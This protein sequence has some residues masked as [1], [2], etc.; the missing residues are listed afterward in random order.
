MIG[1]LALAATL[2]LA[3]E[4]RVAELRAGAT[5]LDERVLAI[6]GNRAIVYRLSD[7]SLRAVPLDDPEKAATIVAGLSTNAYPLAAP[8]LVAWTSGRQIHIAPV[9]APDR[10]TVLSGTPI[11]SLRCNAKAC[12]ATTQYE[13][14]FL[15]LDGTIYARESGGGTILTSDPDGFLLQSSPTL[16]IRVDNSGTFT[17]ISPVSPLPWNAAADFDGQRYAVVWPDNDL[18]AETSTLRAMPVAFNGKTGEPVTLAALPVLAYGRPALATAGGRHLLVFCQPDYNDHIP[19]TVPRARLRAML[20]GAALQPLDAQPFVVDETPWANV[21]AARQRLPRGL[22]P[23]RRQPRHVRSAGG[24]DR[25]GRPR[26]PAHAPLA[27]HRL[28]VRIEHRRDPRRLARRLRRAPARERR[29]RPA[30]RP[31]QS[32]RYG[33][34]RAGPHLD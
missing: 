16:L 4:Q 8:P 34:R 14:L 17:F 22:E 27:R 28:A 11:L 32:R 5:N 2:A 15:R 20:L 25:C 26:R 23:R 12:L 29:R 3:P 6:D 33:A 7:A 31:L 18:I 9:D 13:L 30:H 10:G 24:D 1:T 19:D 21:D